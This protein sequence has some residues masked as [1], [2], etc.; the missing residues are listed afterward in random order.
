MSNSIQQNIVVEKKTG[1]DRH[2]PSTISATIPKK[3]EQD[4]VSGT[5]E[6]VDNVTRF[7]LARLG[8]CYVEKLEEKVMI[9]PPTSCIASLP[10]Y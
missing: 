7:D 3:K 4:S 10:F 5:P 6:E 2:K 9:G 1:V 8:C